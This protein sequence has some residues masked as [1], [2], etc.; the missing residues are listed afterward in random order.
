MSDYEGFEPTNS[1]RDLDA[2][3][4]LAQQQQKLELQIEEAEEKLKELNAQHRDVSERKIPATMDALGMKTFTLKDGYTITIE[5][6]LRVSV[7]AKN[8]NEAYEWVEK[9]GGSPLVKRAFV[10]AFTKEQEAFA[11]KFKRDCD[12]RKNALPMEE[13]MTVASSSLNKF[14]RDKMAEG[15]DVPMALFGAYPQKKSKIKTK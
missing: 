9:H 6:K 13:T 5:E 4:G 2:L 8:K 3:T 1:V 14:L 7:P 12:Q 10:I 15:V 11:R